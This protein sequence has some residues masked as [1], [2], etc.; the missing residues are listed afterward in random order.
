MFEKTLGDLIRG[1]RNNAE[2]E[3]RYVSACLDECRKE[4]SNKDVDI[5][6]NAVAKLTYLQMFGYDVSWAAFNILEGK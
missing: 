1:M 3:A 6:C 2:D 4:L 5:K